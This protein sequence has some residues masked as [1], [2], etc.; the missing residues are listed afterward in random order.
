MAAGAEK[1]RWSGRGTV[2][3]LALSLLFFRLVAACHPSAHT[4]QNNDLLSG[5]V[6]CTPDGIVSLA[7][8]AP[9]P[10]DHDPLVDGCCFNIC[11]SAFGDRLVQVE[12]AKAA[13]P[14]FYLVGSIV[15][16]NDTRLT[17][18]LLNRQS[19]PRAPPRLT[20]DFI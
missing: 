11:F 20:T 15:H 4:V 19:H 18:F 12:L 10:P 17:G 2:A 5:Q 9:T 14:S 16:Q 6:I 7:D 3:F 13:T 1:R 8:K